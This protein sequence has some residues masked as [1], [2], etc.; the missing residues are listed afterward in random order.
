M[1][2]EEGPNDGPPGPRWKVSPALLSGKLR[3]VNLLANQR[4]PPRH[5]QPIT[6]QYEPTKRACSGSPA[7]CEEVQRRCETSTRPDGSRPRTT[8]D[9]VTSRH[10]HGSDRHREPAPLPPGR[11]AGR[12]PEAQHG[13]ERVRADPRARAVRGG[14]GAR[15]QGVHARGAERRARV[16]HRAPAAHARRGRQLRARARHR[17]GERPAGLPP[18]QGPGPLP[19]RTHHL[20]H[21]QARC[22][23]GPPLAEEGQGGGASPRSPAP[24]AQK[25]PSPVDNQHLGSDWSREEVRLFKPARSAS[26]PNPETLG[27]LRV[28]HP[29]ARPPR[30]LYSPASPPPS[31]RSLKP[32]EG[33]RVPR[34]L[35]SVLSRLLGREDD[36]V[37]GGGGE[38]R[39]AEL[40]LYAV[41]QTSRLYLHLLSSWNSFIITST[42]L[43]DPLYRRKC[44]SSRDSSPGRRRPAISGERTAH[45]FAQLRSELLQDAISVESL[46]LLL[47]ELHTAAHR[48]AALRRLFWRSGELCVFLVQTLEESLHGLSG[49]Y[50]ADQLLLS[51]VIVQTLAVMFRETQAEA[52]RL[53]LL[54]AR[55]GSL[56]SRLLLAVICDPR[57]HT[58]SPGSAM[59][60]ELQVLLSEYL[61]AAS[62]LL[63]ELLLLGHKGSR[64]FSAADLLSVGWILRV[65]Q[66]HPHLLCF[67]GHQ[68][69]QVALVL[70]DPRGAPLSP[71]Q[72]VLLFQRCRLLLACLQ[73]D[74]PLAQHLRS[75][76]GEEFRYFVRPS[77]AEEKLPLRYP[78][79]SPTV[80][81]VER[82]VTLM[83]HR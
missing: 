3:T 60:S 75:H 40:H 35:G 12:V 13:A 71:V 22:R 78:I 44:S 18:G 43:L 76:V 11:P 20:R 54:A 77:C 31:E 47:Q 79:S 37:V 14:V 24:F 23:Q 58:Q 46:Y 81:L 63:F 8:R 67:V 80:R 33:R 39:E 50:T 57:L 74:G 55:E 30:L 2:I 32:L 45:L 73:H 7:Q 38:E 56:T 82:I 29:P 70:S 1:T 61:D 25:Q 10:R 6:E 66:P 21:R 69:R 83:L 52:A 5:D 59:D 64:C 41:S 27:L 9:P 36:V 53:N 65:L 51:T 49:V 48:H 15:E 19:A 72:S 26:C 62:S 16:P 68:A 34:R 17:A 4:L 42:L 28:P